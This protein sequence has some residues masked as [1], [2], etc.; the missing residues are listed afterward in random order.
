VGAGAAARVLEIRISKIHCWLGTGV[1]RE[2]GT[3]EILL[4]S[5]QTH[6]IDNVCLYTES[7]TLST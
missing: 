6:I 2:L 1:Y 3:H 5:A 4:K 7:T